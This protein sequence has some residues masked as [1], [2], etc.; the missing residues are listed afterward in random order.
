MDDWTEWELWLYK[1]DASTPPYYYTSDNLQIYIVVYYVPKDILIPLT[2]CS[3]IC[4]TYLICKRL[5]GDAP[6]QFSSGK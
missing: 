1:A 4:T 5:A 2:I 6:H 3:K